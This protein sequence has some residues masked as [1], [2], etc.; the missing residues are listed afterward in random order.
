[1][2]ARQRGFILSKAQAP[3]V[4][5]PLY[6]LC[7]ADDFTFFKVITSGRP[8]INDDGRSLPLYGF[9][10]MIGCIYFA[11]TAYQKVVLIEQIGCFRFQC[12]GRSEERRVGKEVRTYESE[13][14]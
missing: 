10:Q 7:T 3:N 9:H 1:M 6:K 2:H 13:A 12:E 8:Q 11:N 14:Q 4:H 5:I